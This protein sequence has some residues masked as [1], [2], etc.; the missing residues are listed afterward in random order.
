LVFGAALAFGPAAIGT[1]VL[2]ALDA[3]ATVRNVLAY[4]SVPVG[5]GWSSVLRAV[6][7]D[8]AVHN[9]GRALPFLICP[10]LIAVAVRMRR[11]RDLTPF[12]LVLAAFLLLVAI[13]VFGSGY[14][15]QYLF[16]YWPLLLCVAPLTSPTFRLTASV[17]AAVA[18]T[19]YLIEYAVVDYLGS[20]FLWGQHGSFLSKAA[21][22]VNGHLTIVNGPLFLAYAAVFAAGV[23]ETMRRADRAIATEL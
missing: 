1:L 7:G 13:P 10:L 22:Y 19:T 6:G 2:L 4:R 9:Y 15:P 11:S 20:F 21:A 12:T 14:G 18:V 8:M 5:F 16:W 3:D 17:F 23:F